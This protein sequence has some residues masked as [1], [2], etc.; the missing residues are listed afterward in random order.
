MM[1]KRTAEFLETY[2]S[3]LFLYL[4]FESIIVNL[5]NDIYV[6]GP[7]SIV[8]GTTKRRCSD[9]VSLIWSTIAWVVSTYSEVIPSIEKTGLF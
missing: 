4:L 6:S 2:V 9:N 1:S 8:I 7:K 3:T 5:A